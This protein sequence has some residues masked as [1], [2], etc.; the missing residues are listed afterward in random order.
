MTCAPAV[1]TDA[2][3]DAPAPLP[4]TSLPVFGDGYPEAGDPCRRF[5]ESAETIEFLDH[6]RDL[7]GCPE[8]WSGREAYAASVNAEEVLRQDGWVLYSIPLGI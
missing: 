4:E 3:A 8:A 6:T 1:E 2:A 7:V 5:G